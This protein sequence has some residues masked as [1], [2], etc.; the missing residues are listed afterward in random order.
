[1]MACRPEPQRRSICRPG[2]SIRKP[3]SSAATRPMAG[4]SPFGDS[5]PENDIV[6]DRRRVCRCGCDDFGDDG[7]GQGL[8]RRCRG[9]TPPNRATGV[10]S[11]SQMTTPQARAVLY[12]QAI[13][14]ELRSRVIASAVARTAGTRSALDLRRGVARGLGGDVDRG[15]DGPG[16][17]ADRRGQRAQ[18]GLEFLVD[19]AVSGRAHP[20]SSARSCAG[21]SSVRFGQRGEPH[22]A[23]NRRPARRAR[24]PAS[25]TRPIEVA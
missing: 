11:G 10:R 14:R 16:L 20:S 13:W 17:V 15:D 19:D 18:P 23:R 5:L 24:S 4:A 25:S 1:M 2:T 8:R 21:V 9:R 12:W 6:D 7:R 3:A 22:R